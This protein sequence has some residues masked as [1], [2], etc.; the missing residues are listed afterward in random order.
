MS[1]LLRKVATVLDHMALRLDAEDDTATQQKTAAQHAVAK[2]WQDRLAQL[3][4]NDIPENAVQKLAALDD[5]DINALLKQLTEKVAGLNE[6]PDDLGH[7]N[8]TQG[9]TTPLEGRTRV[10]QAAAE[11][12]SAFLQWIMNS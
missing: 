8:D 3:T 1:D 2:D 4:G 9:V 7:I 11:A 10:K 5:G 6:A 12:D